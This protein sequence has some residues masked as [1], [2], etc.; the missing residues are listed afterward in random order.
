MSNL[1]PLKGLKLTTFVCAA[2]KVSDLSPLEDM[3][4]TFL[5]LNQSPVS[6]LTPLKGMPLRNLQCATTPVSDL[7][8]LKGMPLNDLTL[9]GCG[10]VSDLSP[11]KDVKLT[12]LDLQRH[13]GD[14]SFAAEGGA[15]QTP[16]LQLRPERDAEVLRS[17]K[18]LETIN[19][20]AAAEFWKQVDTT[21]PTKKP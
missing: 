8:P 21:P 19:D 20:K 1:S 10:G 14:G 11:L 12:G 4:L 18:T 2:T 17:I 7:T 16:P 5:M 13:Q 15:P 9:I 6:D 3:P